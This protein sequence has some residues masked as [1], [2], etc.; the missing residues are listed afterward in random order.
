MKAPAAGSP[1]APGEIVSAFAIPGDCV[2]IVPFGKGHIND[3]YLSRWRGADGAGPA[4]GYLHQRINDKVF[5]R[6]DQVME[7]IARV[8]AHLAEALRREGLGDIGRR[9]LTVV[10]A[11]SGENWHRDRAGGWWRTYRFIGGTR[12]EDRVESSAQTGLLGAAIGGFQRMLADL[13]PP[14]LHETIPSFHDMRYRY[15]QLDGALAA[16]AAGRAAGVGAELAFFAANR[17]R[18]SALMEGLENGALPARICHND[19]KLN[20]ILLDDAT[21][22]ALCVVDLDTVMP[23]TALF[24]FGDLVRTVAATAAE[25]ETDLARITFDAGQYRALLAGYLSEAAGFLVPAEAALLAEAG[26]NLA[27]IMGLRF[28][29]DYLAGDVYYKTE[30][31][32]HNL[33]RSRNQIALIRSM[34]AVWGEINRIT[35]EELEKVGL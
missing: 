6:P 21:G 24:D 10:P 27:Q 26:R 1:V 11:R 25:D 16:D 28:L 33:D 8:T 5:R 18:G 19:A 20:N 12:A 13:P 23:G 29:T 14:P 31:P 2:S 32:S 34:D 15:R 7:N 4:A 35:M 3:T 30:R 9:T 22:E 17:E